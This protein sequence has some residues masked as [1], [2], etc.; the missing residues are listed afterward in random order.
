MLDVMGV[1]PGWG[2]IAV[3]V[4]AATIAQDE[5]GPDLFGDDPGFA[6]DIQRFTGRGHQDAL[7]V[8]VAGQFLGGQG[9]DQCF[10][11]PVGGP[12]RGRPQPQ[13]SL[14]HRRSDL[15]GSHALLRVLEAG[16]GDGD[17]HGGWCTTSS[18]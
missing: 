7:H 4:D 17:T 14:T 5:R 15:P 10:T 8:G 18:G 12:D 16:Q 6:P 11:G 9:T 2:F 3:R 1:G 13:R